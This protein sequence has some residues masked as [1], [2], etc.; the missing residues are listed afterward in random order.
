MGREDKA[1]VNVATPQ[2]VSQKRL[3]A[4]RGHLL[5]F[6]LF[7]GIF[8]LGVRGPILTCLAIALIVRMQK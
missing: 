3:L 4:S 5:I 1:L 7:A 6:V 8:E 2:T